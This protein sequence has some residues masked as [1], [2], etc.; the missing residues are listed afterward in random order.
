MG[1]RYK[2]LWILCDLFKEGHVTE[3]NELHYT[4]ATRRTMDTLLQFYF[5]TGLIWAMFWSVK[6]SLTG[7]QNLAMSKPL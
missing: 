7:I 2:K 5:A 1:G 6:L 3:P 4:F